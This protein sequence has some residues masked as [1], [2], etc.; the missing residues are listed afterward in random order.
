MKKALFILIIITL[1]VVVFV[2]FGPVIANRHDN[3]TSELEVE[4]IRRGTL[5][6]FV[7][8]N[9]VVQ[10]NQSALLLWKIPGEVREVNVE[11]GDQVSAG[12]ILAT[13]D[14]TSLPTYIIIAQ[15]DLLNNNVNWQ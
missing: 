12:D 4:T 15:T 5:S 8:A 14:T 7:E 11:S 1:V 2:A 13:L 10:S 3:L 9:G 6:A